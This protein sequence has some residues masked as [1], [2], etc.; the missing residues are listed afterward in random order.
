M[1]NLIFTL[2]FS[3]FISTQVSAQ[4]QIAEISFIK[5]SHNFGT[6]NE[7]DGPKAYKFIFKNTGKKPLIISNVKA[8]CG[9][10]TPEWTKAPIAS[11]KSG[12]IK[13]S[14]D[15]KNRPGPFNKSITVS[16]N[17]I[18]SQKK[19]IIKGS[20]KERIKTMDD[21][22]RYTME[23]LKLKSNHIA[24]TKVF[25]TDKKTEILYIFNPTDKK[26]SM[27]FDRIPSHISLDKTKITVNPKQKAQ[28]KITY[29][30]LKKKDWG[31][32]TDRILV[33]VN[34]KR[35]P[36][37]R[38]TVS[39][40]IQE[41][42]SKLTETQLKQAPKAVFGNSI[43]NFGEINEGEIRNYKFTFKNEGKSD[44]VIR[45]L[46]SS[47]GCAIAKMDSKTIKAG[48]SSV[49]NVTFNSKGKTGKQL[50]TITV[51]TNDPR[52]YQTTLRVKGNILNTKK[53]S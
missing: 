45:K 17:A 37:N 44:L 18:H 50:K 1:K 19:L 47:C 30:A 23:G 52:K 16:S 42:F 36:K 8:S 15:P 51:I 33:I 29:D 14:F 48:Q 9:C 12:Y 35:D 38:I 28:V 53:K 39:A 4:T 31:F 21:K 41:D 22:Y 27:Q 2:L 34:N 3:L 6:I 49:I 13:V 11:G 24:M 20:V 5:E 26:I 10:T 32:V 46:K 7:I 43:F 25:N 40:D